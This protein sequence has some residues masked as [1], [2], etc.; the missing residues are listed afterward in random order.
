MF[1]ISYFSIIILN[2]L[3]I[4]I[5]QMECTLALK[6][7][8]D[9]DKVQG[10]PRT[11]LDNSNLQLR[12]AKLA[13]QI[14]N[15]TLLLRIVTFYLHFLQKGENILDHLND[16]CLYIVKYTPDNVIPL[17]FSLSEFAV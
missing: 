3:A 10:F 4:S 2:I 16:I 5:Y 11:P 1:K 17:I 14:S 15:R 12:F 13:Q 9:N 8:V 7:K 6:G